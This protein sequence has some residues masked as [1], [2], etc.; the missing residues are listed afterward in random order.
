[1]VRYN[2]IYKSKGDY[3][4]VEKAIVHPKYSRFG[5]DYDIAILHLDRPL[6]NAQPICLPKQNDDP[7]VYSNVFIT[8]WGYL[9]EEI[10]KTSERLMAVE[11]PVIDRTKCQEQLVDNSNDPESV[12]VS[13]RM[14][15]AGTTEGGKDSC[16]GDSG[17]PVISFDKKDTATIRGIVSWGIGCGRPRLAGVNTRVGSFVDNFIQNNLI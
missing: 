7:F 11:I 17:G 15:C 10:H 2:T 3:V 1:M 16:Q 9:K 13:E 8:G 6:N 5:H 12:K 4:K 14:F